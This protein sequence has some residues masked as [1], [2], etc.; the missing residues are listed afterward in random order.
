M[1]EAGEGVRS[2]GVG[3]FEGV[4]RGTALLGD[5]DRGTALLEAALDA[6]HR[7]FGHVG[8]AFDMRHCRLLRV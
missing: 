8:D 1:A 7:S 2:V 5:L 3:R 4:Q 6:R